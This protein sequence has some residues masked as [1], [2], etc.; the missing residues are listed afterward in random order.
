MTVPASDI[1]VHLAGSGI[2]LTQG[3]NL[4]TGPIRE[5]SSVGN[6]PKDA[7][8]VKGLPGGLP[9]RTMGQE[10]EIRSPLVTIQVRNTGFNDGDT[11]ARD[12]QEVMQG[13]EINGYLDIDA[14]QSE[15]FYI[16][17]DNEGLHMWSLIYRL[18][19]ID[20]SGVIVGI[21]SSDFSE[22]FK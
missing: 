21:F 6:V 17:Q 11:G 9:E 3:T 7:V 16:G 18:K 20:N 5:V 14:Q 10:D 13:V 8:F 15:P 12:I 4:F 2:S 22:E 19:Y 1:A